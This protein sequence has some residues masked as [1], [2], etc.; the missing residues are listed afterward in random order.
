M[1]NNTI[2]KEDEIDLI[3]LIQKVWK[4]K[5]SIALFTLIFLVIGILAALFASKE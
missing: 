4:S 5:K 3:A 2:E 1:E